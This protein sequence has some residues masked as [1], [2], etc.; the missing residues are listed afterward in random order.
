MNTTAHNIAL[1]ANHC[2]TGGNG[3]DYKGD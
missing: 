3:E 1:S 2:S